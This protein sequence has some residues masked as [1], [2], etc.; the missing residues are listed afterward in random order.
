MGT[1]TTLFTLISLQEPKTGIYKCHWQPVITI[2]GIIETDDFYNC[3]WIVKDMAMEVPD[4]TEKNCGYFLLILQHT[5]SK[6][7]A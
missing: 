2:S 7:K 3:Y 4:V 1:T 5:R 6:E